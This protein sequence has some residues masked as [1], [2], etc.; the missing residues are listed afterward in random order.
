MKW[1]SRINVFNGLTKGNNV[2]YSGKG[3]TR[4][5][6]EAKGK[7]AELRKLYST[8]FSAVTPPKGRKKNPRNIANTK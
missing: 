4:K 1:L 3:R 2:W 8:L 5:E 6:I 7:Q